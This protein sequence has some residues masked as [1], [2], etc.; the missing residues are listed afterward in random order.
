MILYKFQIY[1]IIYFFAEIFK[2]TSTLNVQP[3]KQSNLNEAQLAKARADIAVAPSSK[4]SLVDARLIICKL[5]DSPQPSN[6]GS[7]SLILDAP[8]NHIN[9]WNIDGIF[10]R[11]TNTPCYTFQPLKKIIGRDIRHH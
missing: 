4:I 11:K 1:Y 6:A 9:Q 8:N 5:T 10:F 2:L 3:S 7:T